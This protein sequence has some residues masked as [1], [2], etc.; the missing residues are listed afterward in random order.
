MN[1]YDKRLTAQY[2]LESSKTVREN[3]IR[4]FI[5]LIPNIPYYNVLSYRE[6]IL[7]NAQ[8]IAIIRAMKDEGKSTEDTLRIQ[9]ELF[10]EDWGKV[11]K[12]MGRIF[13]SKFG[14]YFLRRLAAM[15]TAEGWDTEYK[16][17]TQNDDFNVS[18]VTH[19]C[20]LV[21]Y[22]KSEGVKQSIS[23]IKN[24]SFLN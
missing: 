10:K 15:V 9:A 22:L 1:R 23:K 21:E 2:V 18:I 17:G 8:I 3:A 7:I 24:G 4:H 6:I 13:V 19:N 14:G 11:P 20:G 12:F 16:K 5:D